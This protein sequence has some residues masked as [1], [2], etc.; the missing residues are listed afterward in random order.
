M[1]P[2]ARR[3]LAGFLAAGTLFPALALAEGRGTRFAAF[4]QTRPEKAIVRVEAGVAELESLGFDLARHGSE[5][6][7]EPV[8]VVASPDDRER[9]TR[10]GFRWSEG[11]RPVPGPGPEGDWSDLAGAMARL[12]ELVAANPDLLAS[13]EVGRSIQGRPIVGVRAST[14]PGA[15]DPDRPKVSFNGNH[16]AREVMTVEVCLDILGE[17][18]RRYREGDPSAVRWLSELEIYVTPVVNPDGYAFVFSDDDW[19]R[20][21]RRPNANGSYGVD[22]NRNY[23][24]AWGAN[25]SGSSGSPWSETYRGS[26][27]ASE[28]EVA[29]MVALARELRPVFNLS[30][31]SY[32]EVLL[33]PY[34]YEE[35][36]NPVG[37]V[38]EDLSTQIASRMTRDSGQGHF[39][40]RSRLYPVNGLDRDWY[41]FELGTYSFVPEISSSD[42]GFHPPHSWVAPTVS[43][44]RAAWAF[45]LERTLGSG[46]R[47]TVRS[48]AT[49]ETV[50]VGKATLD[51][52]QWRNGEPLSLSARGDFHKLVAPGTYRLRVEAAG[53]QPWSGEVTVGEG[54]V[55]LGIELAPVSPAAPA[56]VPVR[57]VPAAP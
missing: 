34:G 47:G 40:K 27:P 18:V 16:H 10:L 5:L 23:P 44:L 41:Y 15:A 31:H 1:T 56:L 2:T 9:L 36:K 53:Y 8:D 24:Y 21:N 13:F 38:M 45:V 26:G 28:P 42:Q 17:L 14:S 55:R 22:L 37:D 52:V 33:Y 19:W 35:A 3:W 48:A 57:P 29:A 25:N 11:P 32:S 51:E 54:L 7:G 43:G 30:F 50:A 49:G 12:E 46:I 6:P 39:D 4:H 20:K